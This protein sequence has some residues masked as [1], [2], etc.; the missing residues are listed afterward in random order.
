[1]QTRTVVRPA[2]HLFEDDV[3]LAVFIENRFRDTVAFDANFVE[4]M[5]VKQ[6][7]FWSSY[8]TAE[9]RYLMFIKHRTA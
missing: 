4:K 2:K 8:E 1:M 3:L 5:R 6:W 7:R 9:G